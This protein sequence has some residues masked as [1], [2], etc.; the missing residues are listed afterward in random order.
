MDF[1][2]T[3]EQERF[4]SELRAWLEHKKAEGSFATREHKSLDQAVADG[5][6][7]QKTLYEGGWCGIH[8]PREYGGR[9][10]SLLEQIIFQEELA[11]A[12]SPQLINLLAL[13]MVGPVIIAYGTEEQKS[14]YLKPI[15]T[16][17]EIW[18][19][20]Y[21]EPG[22][23]SDLASLSTRAVMEG[24][25][26]L[27]S[28]QKVWTSYAQYADFCILL[29]RTNPDVP[30]HKGITMFIVDMH[31]PGIEV[32]P[33][34]QM[35]GDSEF[36]EVYLEDVRVPR[37]NIIGKEGAGWDM[38]VALLMHERATLTFQR[39]LQSRV[40]L[41]DLLD[42]ARTWDETGS[43]PADDPI[44]RQRIAQAYIDSE[45][46][47]LTALRNLTRQLRGGHPGPEGSIEKL[48]WSEMFQRMLWNCVAMLGPYGNLAPEDPLAPAQGRWPHLM[49]YSRGRTIAAGTS[50]IQRGII[51]QR[52]L[53][54]PKD[55]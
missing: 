38:A 7:W 36:N 54:M 23:G 19:Q 12:G 18:C 11:R 48:F 17:D 45:A 3:A 52:V 6:R 43:R 55:R 37:A 32:R 8:W 42:F 2:Y 44:V 25:D 13:T 39:Q 49:L 53:G 9:S 21:S 5:R 29:A 31:S 41:Q 26:Y 34:K 4:R 30:K 35:N 51:A 46:I 20:G 47:R 33:L 15:L 22:A 27:I 10:A 40:A 50:E 1:A 14:R 16:A 28:G 24:D